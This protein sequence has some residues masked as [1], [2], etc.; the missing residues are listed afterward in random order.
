MFVCARVCV[1]VCVCACVFVCVYIYICV[2]VCAVDTRNDK[3]LIKCEADIRKDQYVAVRSVGNAMFTGIGIVDDATFQSI[4]KCEVDTR[5]AIFHM[6]CEVFA[7]IC[8][9][10][11]PASSRTED[12]Q[13]EEAGG[14]LLVPNPHCHW[15]GRG[16]QYGAEP[17]G[18]ACWQVHELTSDC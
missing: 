5:N 17:V 8:M 14:P 1:C 7:K 16:A 4:M 11:S 9:A 12:S 13:E 18:A 3:F 6:K 2:C 10:T 15:Y